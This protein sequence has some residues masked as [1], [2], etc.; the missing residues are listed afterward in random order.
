[1][2][3]HQCIPVIR[4]LMAGCKWQAVPNATRT[5]TPATTG[6][7]QSVLRTSSPLVGTTA[8]AALRLRYSA[9][10][11]NLKR[12]HASTVNCHQFVR[13]G[14]LSGDRTGRTHPLAQ[15]AW[16]IRYACKSSPPARENPSPQTPHS[17]CSTTVN[18]STATC[19]CH[20]A[21]PPLA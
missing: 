11:N 18:H 7:S 5:S 12:Y 9:N 21:T 10:P 3:Q 15:G 17:P 2:Q 8:A 4:S 6:V 19:T 1:M 13:V 20:L 14:Q 16:A